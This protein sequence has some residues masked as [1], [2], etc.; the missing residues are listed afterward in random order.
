[1]HWCRNSLLYIGVGTVCCA[2]VSEQFAVHW[3]RN[4][5]LY[6]GVGTVCCALVFYLFISITCFAD[7]PIVPFVPRL[8][9]HVPI[10]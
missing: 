4:S 6:I 10:N 2:L 9:R 8:S 7:S 3:C 1:M 5:L